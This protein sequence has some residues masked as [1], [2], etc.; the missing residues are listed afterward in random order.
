M[1]E[2]GATVFKLFEMTA[3]DLSLVAVPEAEPLLPEAEDEDDPE[4]LSTSL[5]LS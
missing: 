1:E 4:E 5:M 2:V 3:V